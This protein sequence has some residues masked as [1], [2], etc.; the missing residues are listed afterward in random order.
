M[1]SLFK[2]MHDSLL[3]SVLIFFVLV[4]ASLQSY[5]QIR[6]EPGY[7]ISNTGEKT[8]CLIRNQDWLQTPDK[9]EY[10]LTKDSEVLVA[11]VEDVKE[12]LITGQS[13]YIRAVVAIDRSS[14]ALESL[15]KQKAPIFQ[16]ESLFLRVLVEGDASLFEY[17]QNQLVRFFYKTVKDSLSQLVYKRYIV[18]ATSHSQVYENA[19][20][21]QQLYNDVSCPG[22]TM[23]EMQRIPYKREALE[24]IFKKYNACH[25]QTPVET[26]PKAKENFNLTIRPGLDVINAYFIQRYYRAKFDLNK[27]NP[28]LGVELEYLLPFNKKKWSIA[29]EPTYHRFKKE[30]EVNNFLLVGGRATANID[31]ASVELP[32]TIRHSFFV[33]THSRIFVNISYV[34]D[35]PFKSSEIILRDYKDEVYE[36]AYVS[37]DQN[38]AF[39]VGFNHKRFSLE[40]RHQTNRALT[41]AFRFSLYYGTHYEV[42]SFIIGYSLF[43]KSDKK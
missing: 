5:A 8:E 40:V 2:I 25:G 18:G 12:L 1:K 33:G 27:S 23:N 34:L 35:V 41:D 32:L 38:Y 42:T 15:T 4:T 24:R 20:F 29:I 6:F 14:D 13:R 7:F 3:K 43:Q 30:K 11:R 10:R 16:P 9:F 17:R 36:T 31:Y 21:R 22:T 37:T 39:G 19:Q 26:K 28:R